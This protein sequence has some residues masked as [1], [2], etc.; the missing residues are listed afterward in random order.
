MLRQFSTIYYVKR[1]LNTLSLGSCLPYVAKCSLAPPAKTLLSPRPYS[2]QGS[3]RCTLFKVSVAVAREKWRE[4]D[5]LDN[6]L[7]K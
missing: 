3:G 1:Q 2:Q 6:K 7:V 4:P 5:L